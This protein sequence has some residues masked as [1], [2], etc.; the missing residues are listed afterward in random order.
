[1]SDIVTVNPWGA[2]TQFT[3]AR[4][5]L[6]R[7][8]TSLPTRPHLDFQFAHARA[9]NAVHHEFDHQAV[10]AQLAERKLNVLSLISA[11]KTRPIYL[12]RPDLGRKL[13]DESLEQLKT[14]SA[15]PNGFDISIVVVDGLSSFAIEQN[16][17]QFLDVLLPQLAARRYSISP[18]AVVRQGRV[19]IGDPICQSL[20]ARLVIVLIGERPGLSSPDSLGCYITWMPCQQSTD[21]DR[22][23][24]SNIRRGG[25]DFSGAAHKLMY[26]IDQ[27]FER[28]LSGVNLKDETEA[29]PL[30]ASGK[31][32]NFLLE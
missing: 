3:Q 18:V 17:I 9:R 25:I 8:G 10:I 26:L 7:A 22:N 4:I 12:Q 32:R 1:M 24:I 15:A 31:G 5:A 6:G 28:Q 27:A 11:A 2:L 13:S 23:C 29:K 16:A 20:N 19:A 21:A 30:L 14:L